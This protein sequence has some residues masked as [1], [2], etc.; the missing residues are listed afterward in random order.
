MARKAYT[1]KD[2][3]A[4]IEAHD[5]VLGEEEKHAGAAGDFIK[6]LVFGGLDGI[7]TTFAIVCAAVGASLSNKTVIVMGL[8]NLIADA[9]SMG[10]GDALS[11]KAEMDM[12][13]REWDRENWEMDN[14]P[15]GEIMEMVELYKD[16][17]VSQDDAYIILKT[18][19]KYKDFFVRH[20]M[21]MELELQAP[22]PE[23][24]PWAM[25]AVTFMA[26]ILFGSVPLV[27]FIFFAAV[28]VT[29]DTLFALCILFTALAI[30]ALGAVKG[31]FA[32]SSM[33]KAGL[34][35]TLNGGLAAAAS[36]FIGWGLE[37]FVP[38]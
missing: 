8:A 3:N 38:E 31:K 29:G 15:E 34:L 12:V 4:M 5:T 30:F 18:M 37:S 32:Q 14:N 21:V 24:N 10:L 13:K 33:L 6:S 25:G 19:A 16:A 11:E 9:I 22:N 28:G 23:D 35:M 2:V 20:M 7:I 27:S 36:Y 26:F 1:V 17:G